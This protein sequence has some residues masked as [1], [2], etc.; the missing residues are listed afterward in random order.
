MATNRMQQ[1][2]TET[3]LESGLTPIQEQAAI[4]LASGENLSLIH[5]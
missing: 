1:N 2:P 4:M 3:T 5:I